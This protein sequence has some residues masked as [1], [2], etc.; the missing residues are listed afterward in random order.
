[1]QGLPIVLMHYN[2]CVSTGIIL[3][4]YI[5]HTEIHGHI[6]IDYLPEW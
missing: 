5:M 4:T 2:E 6:V 1:M 3:D